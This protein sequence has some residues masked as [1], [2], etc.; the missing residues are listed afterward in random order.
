MRASVRS[1]V[2]SGP[3]I[4]EVHRATS[5]TD[6]YRD[7]R[8]NPNGW[9]LTFLATSASETFLF[10]IFP[11][12]S[13]DYF[14]IIRESKIIADNMVKCCR[15]RQRCWPKV[16]VHDPVELNNATKIATTKISIIDFNG[17]WTQWHGI[18]RKRFASCGGSP[19][20][21]LA[22]KTNGLGDHFGHWN[23][24]LA[25]KGLTI[26]TEVHEHVFRNMITPSM[27]DL[28]LHSFR[29][30]TYTSFKVSVWDISVMAVNNRAQTIWRFLIGLIVL[31][32]EHDNENIELSCHHRSGLARKRDRP[33]DVLLSHQR[34]CLFKALSV[35]PK[36]N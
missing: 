24:T 12:T 18:L 20:T 7:N 35:Y 21:L 33:N 31:A 23:K 10:I 32:D 2:I 28:N 36:V 1:G 34:W 6:Q 30:Q 29:T 11:H 17:G 19:S 27:M 5:S 13:W 9:N 4:I 8:H 3:T 15:C 14:H 22:F 16:N 25:R 26:A